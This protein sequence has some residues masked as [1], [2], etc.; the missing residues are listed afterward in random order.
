MNI[1]TIKKT[2][3]TMGYGILGTICVALIL[4]TVSIPMIFAIKYNTF[5]PVLIYIP[6][7]LNT[8][9]NDIE[10]KRKSKNYR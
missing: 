5:Y 10:N 3:I 1:L 2:L 8:V 6:F 9:G 4:L 7:V